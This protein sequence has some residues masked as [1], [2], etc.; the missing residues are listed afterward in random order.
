M[1]PIKSVSKCK[2]F[3]FHLDLVFKN[4]Y[5]HRANTLELPAQHHMMPESSRV[6]AREIPYLAIAGAIC[7]ACKSPRD[8]SHT[9]KN[10]SGCWKATYCSAKCQVQHWK[11]EHKDQCKIFRFVG[12]ET[13]QSH[14]LTWDEYGKLQVRL[15]PHDVAITLPSQWLS[16]CLP[17]GSVS[18]YCPRWRN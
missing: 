10:C 12:Q 7:W 5:S 15:S 2:Q 1:T 16:T 4:Y 18:V 8:D 13:T 11:D 3:H 17:I 14:G 6:K 9:L